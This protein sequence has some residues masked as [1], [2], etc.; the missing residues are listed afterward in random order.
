M[1]SR[2]KKD[3]VISNRISASYRTLVFT[4]LVMSGLAACGGGGSGGGGVTPPPPPAVS[5]ETVADVTSRD[6][7]LGEQGK[8]YAHVCPGAPSGNGPRSFLI[9]VNGFSP[10]SVD[11]QPASGEL[12]SVCDGHSSS[13]NFH[14][15]QTRWSTGADYIQRNAGFIRKLIEVLDDKYAI[16]SD[17]RLALVGYSMGGLVSRY[18]L[19]SMETEGVAHNIDLFVSVDSPQLGAYVPIGVQHIT[20]AFRDKGGQPMLNILNTPASRQM[21]LYHYSQ[22]RDAQTWTDDHQTLFV[23]ELQGILG[24]FV[25]TEGMRTV[26]VSSGRL[27][28]LLENPAPGVQYFGGELKRSE[29]FEFTKTVGSFPCKK[30]LEFDVNVDIFVKS[31]A[32]SLALWVM[33][34]QLQVQ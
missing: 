6:S 8:G 15:V 23:D 32:W 12:E 2:T 21:L 1:Y 7:F 19:Q 29:D 31:Q 14:L 22:G 30:T 24:G 9:V 3:Q 28:G 33:V 26:A 5:M 16:T 18:A 11:R 10:G 17:D 20:N 25:R 34:G 4:A 13:A 27:D